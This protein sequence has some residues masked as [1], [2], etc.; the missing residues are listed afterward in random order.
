MTEQ[1]QLTEKETL[2]Y[3]TQT[4][5]DKI[6]QANQDPRFTNSQ[7]PTGLPFRQSKKWPL[8]FMEIPLTVWEF[9]YEKGNTKFSGSSFL[10]FFPYPQKLPDVCYAEDKKRWQEIGLDLSRP[11]LEALAIPHSV[12]SNHYEEP[13]QEIF[14][15]I[16]TVAESRKK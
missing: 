8:R 13:L 12:V 9:F 16:E 7:D 2:D 4:L 5:K 10:Y 3:I 14:R 6:N 11:V 1:K 15:Q